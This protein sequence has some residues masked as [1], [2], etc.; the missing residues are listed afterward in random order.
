MGLHNTMSEPEGV[1]NR[2]RQK[3]KALS[4]YAPVLKQ[5]QPTRVG[6]QERIMLRTHSNQ[7]HEHQGSPLRNPL[8]KKRD[9]PHSLKVLASIA[10]CNH[11]DLYKGKKQELPPAVLQKLLK[12]M[13]QFGLLDDTNLGFFLSENM[14]EL[15]LHN[16]KN[17]ADLTEKS[18]SLLAFC[19]PN[20]THLSLS[21][22]EKL[23][24][25]GWIG[26]CE[27]L[28]T[29]VGTKL[30]SLSLKHL[31]LNPDGITALKHFKHLRHL[32][33]NSAE[34]N[35]VNVMECLGDCCG[36]TLET[37]DLTDVN[38]SNDVLLTL[39]SK[40]SNLEKLNLTVNKFDPRKNYASSEAIETISN[41]LTLKEIYLSG[42]MF[43]DTS[44]GTICSKIPNLTVLVLTWPDLNSEYV[45]TVKITENVLP[46]IGSCSQLTELGLGYCQRIRSEQGLV[47]LVMFLSRLEKLNLSSVPGVGDN[48]IC[49]VA[50][51]CPNMRRLK[52][53]D[54]I[55]N[56]NSLFALAKHC[57]LL[58]YLDVRGKTVQNIQ[59]DAA[60]K[61]IAEGC[62]DLQSVFGSISSEARL[63]LQLHCSKLK[64]KIKNEVLTDPFDFC[65]KIWDE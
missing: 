59:T 12:V 48:L 4:S 14:S 29:H 27:T 45:Y 7:H 63:H 39:T 17:N 37:F 44:I 62:P 11:V 38:L 32:T 50:Q 52:L 36:E 55:V 65:E 51:S 58:E 23:T 24:P 34:V 41:I 18:L 57:P 5:K 43:D 47:N 15:E 3:I 40:F 35:N 53:Q 56:S 54:C 25:K 21:N 31:R 22:W 30:N 13:L 20:L 28:S 46:H 6:S 8:T 60:W 9:S 33:I 26:Y 61:E 16:A 42:M 1:N 2:I 64:L 10:V 19:C 49:K